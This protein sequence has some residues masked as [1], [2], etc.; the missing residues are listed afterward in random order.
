MCHVLIVSFPT[1]HMTGQPKIDVET[2]TKIESMKC[3]R[4]HITFMHDM[5]KVDTQG[6]GGATA[7]SP[8]LTANHIKLWKRHRTQSE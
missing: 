4:N 2:T 1:S 6:C 3:N 7:V 5:A 8:Y